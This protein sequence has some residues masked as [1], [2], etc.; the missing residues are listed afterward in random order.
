MTPLRLCSV[1]DHIAC[2]LFPI[3]SDPTRFLPRSDLKGHGE[4]LKLAKYNPHVDRQTQL[5]T[6]VLTDNNFKPDFVIESQNVDNGGQD[7][8]GSWG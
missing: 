5:F 8:L 2:V 7:L 1:S 3:T 6:R 4:P